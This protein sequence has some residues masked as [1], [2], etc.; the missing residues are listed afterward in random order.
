MLLDTLNAVA[1]RLGEWIPI[2]GASLVAVYAAVGIWIPRLRPH[3]KGTQRR[4]GAISCAGF[5]L[6]FGGMALLFTV[7]RTVS[8]DAAA[9]VLPVIVGGFVLVFIGALKDSRGS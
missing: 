8:H 6:A 5:A 3:W 9:K 4:A 1:R 2:A 7:N